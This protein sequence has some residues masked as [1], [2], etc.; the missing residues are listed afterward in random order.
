LNNRSNDIAK[1]HKR[2]KIDDK[3][4][5]QAL[6]ELGFEKYVEP[7]KDFMA[8]YNADKEDQAAAGRQTAKKRAFP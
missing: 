2:K 3:D 1:E 5:L 7:L 8:N 6:N 4:V